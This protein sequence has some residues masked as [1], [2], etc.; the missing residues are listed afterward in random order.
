MVDDSSLRTI[1]EVYS[2]RRS[3]TLLSRAG[4][5]KQTD[6][7]RVE[8]FVQG[9]A[10]TEHLSEGSDGPDRATKLREH[11]LTFRQDGRPGRMGHELACDLQFWK[12]FMTKKTAG[13]EKG[14]VQFRNK[15]FERGLGN[16]GVGEQVDLSC[17]V[18]HGQWQP[19]S[20][21]LT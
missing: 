17:T 3:L 5:R 11:L 12:N 18:S 10:V 4:D 2:A 21:N 14:E 8:I 13:R 19:L 1:D 15:S 16:V 7:V 9:A 20:V 6:K